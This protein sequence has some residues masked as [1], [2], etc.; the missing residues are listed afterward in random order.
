MPTN[1]KKKYPWEVD[2]DSL[3]IQ[4]PKVF[5][6]YMESQA[7]EFAPDPT[8]LKY[9]TSDEAL[10]K[11]SR[12][13]QEQEINRQASENYGANLKKNKKNKKVKPAKTTSSN[14]GTTPSITPS[15]GVVN[16]YGTA[17]NPKAPSMG[18]VNPYGIIA[19]SN[20]SQ[21]T[22]KINSNSSKTSLN[23]T[24]DP[25]GSIISK[26]DAW[27]LNA[28]NEAKKR[29]KKLKKGLKWLLFKSSMKRFLNRQIRL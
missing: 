29:L 28:E 8:S 12:I 13:L 3:K 7:R 26:E 19:P 10:G 9:L 23:G 20:T 11:V 18:A 24:I 25:Y 21:N 4:D 5:K 15:I 14:N 17:I 6:G 1:K 22:D 27:K 16:P 2:K